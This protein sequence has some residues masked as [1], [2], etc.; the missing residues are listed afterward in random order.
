MAGSIPCNTTDEKFSGIAVW[1]TMKN[2]TDKWVPLSNTDIPRANPLK[3]MILSILCLMTIVA[4]SCAAWQRE[5]QQ[6]KKK[7]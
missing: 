6:G 5:P 4:W 1:V 3:E 2:V 7:R